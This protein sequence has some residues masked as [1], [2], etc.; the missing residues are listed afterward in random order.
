MPTRGVARRWTTAAVLSL[1]PKVI[2]AASRQ[3]ARRCRLCARRRA[4]CGL[5]TAEAGAPLAHGGELVRV[6]VRGCTANDNDK[7]R[8][9]AVAKSDVVVD[10][11]VASER[12]GKQSSKSGGRA[13]LKHM[14]L[15][16]PKAALVLA[17]DERHGNTRQHGRA[18]A[19]RA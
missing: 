17:L 1:V 19:R 3:G 9:C 10:V 14:S 7:E 2:A 13:E 5:S 16:R 8:E 15:E 4:V 11:V 18:R 12:R 6:F